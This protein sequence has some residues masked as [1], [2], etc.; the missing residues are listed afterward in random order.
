MVKNNLKNSILLFSAAF[1]WGTSF[2]FQSMGNNYMK[3]FTF[4]AARSFLGFLVLLPIAIYKIKKVNADRKNYDI[5]EI[6]ETKIPFKATVIGGL[7]CGLALTGASLFQQYGV[8][9]TTVSKAGFIT[10]LYIILIPILGIFL[11]KKCPWTVWI[12]A[13]TACIGMY[14]LCMTESFSLSFGDTLVLICAFLFAIHILII[15]YFSP[16]TDGVILSCIQFLIC[17]LV[18]SI[19]TLIFDRPDFSQIVEG[20]VPILYTGIMS[21]GVAYTFQILGQKNFNP[22]AA[23]LILSL[24]SV[25]SAISSFIAYQLGFLSSDQS[26]STLQIIG[27]II[28]FTAV[29]FVQLPISSLSHK[30]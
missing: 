21:S 28:V 11:K 16:K 18:S 12:S 29:I 23:A 19:L 20:I 3:P 13:V 9:Y 1:I 24:E 4:S 25:I 17:F 14:F 6:S 10:T 7:C 26:L 30:K 27:C 5:S 2:V 8:K 15:D 22:T